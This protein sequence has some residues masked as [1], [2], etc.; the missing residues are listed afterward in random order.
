MSLEAAVPMGAQFFHEGTESRPDSHMAL[1]SVNGVS[2]SGGR[3]V[4]IEK[5]VDQTNL[6]GLL[7]RPNQYVLL[8]LGIKNPLSHK[9]SMASAASSFDSDACCK[10]IFK[11]LGIP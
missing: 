6:K 11:G 9:L 7:G 1:P 3:G 8:S 2:S 5:M 4:V 10:K